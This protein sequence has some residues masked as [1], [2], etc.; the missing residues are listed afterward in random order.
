MAS[1]TGLQ[2]TASGNTRSLRHNADG[3][4]EMLASLTL[5]DPTDVTAPTLFQVTLGN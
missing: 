4:L 1:A 2:G 3:Q 5:G